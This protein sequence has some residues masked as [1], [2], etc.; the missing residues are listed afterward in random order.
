MHIKLVM[1][2]G[3]LAI[4]HLFACNNNDND[5]VGECVDIP[6]PLEW[7]NHP[8]EPQSALFSLEFEATPGEAPMDAVIGLS[9]GAAGGYA[10]L[11]ATVRL[12]SDG[13]ID[14]RD[15]GQYNDPD[16]PIPY[17]A[18]TSYV[19]RLE[20]DVG[21][22]LYNAYVTPAGGSEQVIGRR[23]SFRTEQQSADQ[24]DNLATIGNASYPDATHQVCDIQLSQLS[25]FCGNAAT[26][27]G[28]QCDGGD[29]CQPDTCTLSDASQVCRPARDPECDLAET[30][31]GV[32]P[33]C[34][35][36]EVRE[37]SCGNNGTCVDGVCTNITGTVY[38]VDNTDNNASDDNAGTDPSA[39]WLTIG[40]CASTLVAG[41]ACMVKTGGVYDERVSESTSGAA[42]GP[43]AYQA[44]TG[45][46][47]PV[48]RGFTISG[49]YVTIEGFEITN[50]GMSDDSTPSILHS[51]TDNV[52][53]RNNYFH[54]TSGIAI[55]SSP[56]ASSKSTNCVISGNTIT[57]IGP[58]TSR[59]IGIQVWADHCLIEDNDISHVEDHIR[60]HGWYFVVRNNTWHD[61]YDAEAPGAHFDGWQSF[62]SSTTESANFTLIEGNQIYDMPDS[63]SHF[64]LI[65]GT[66]ACG[67]TTTVV[68]RHNVVLKNLGSGF[69]YSDDNEQ[70]MAIYHKVYNNTVRESLR[71]T[72]NHVTVT[73]SGTQY[74]SVL[75]N[76][77]YD[78]ISENPPYNVYSITASS[79]AGCNLAYMS[80]G[81]KSWGTIASE[82]GAV[83]NE[84]PLFAGGDDLT[85]Q[86]GS[87]AIDAGCP[88]TRVSAADTGSG[89]A[90]V[91][92]DARFFQ[93][94]W[95]GVPADWI[96]VGSSDNTAEIVSIDYDANTVTLATPLARSPA[97][98]VWLYKNSTGSTVLRGSAPDIG[99]FES[100][101]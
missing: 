43:I 8:I 7:A 87:P 79:N 56:F 49:D 88:L 18:D 41:D 1:I 3:I 77:F 75:N 82:P 94:G 76:I 32:S 35:A 33:T 17:T 99:A 9:S 45:S 61:N 83:L 70:S 96:A 57:R 66:D 53:I 21:A 44:E 84:N 27:T 71:A 64:G 72:G 36:D 4:C 6:S 23:L 97:E 81:S 54:D 59:S 63:N 85:L 40:K 13:S 95:A 58:P 80:S 16:P 42:G 38:Y 10:D 55:R 47:R 11:A 46:P 62:C 91:V 51:G 28:E 14:A 39:P 25:S 67:G 101:P 93:D 24:L 98:P 26:E 89:T 19:F 86:T 34:P 20:V 31:N 68:V 74:G 65:N 52:Q 37:G 60:N 12:G 48:V 29:C 73:L 50:A 5:Q 69:W 30:C 92:D 2:P 90:L 100:I 22:R 78:A 15:G